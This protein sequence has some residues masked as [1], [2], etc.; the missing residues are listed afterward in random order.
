ELG[1]QE[2]V[3]GGKMSLSYVGDLMDRHFGSSWYTGSAL[4]IK[5]TNIVWPDDTIVAKAVVTDEAVEDG[6]KMANV[7]VWMEKQDGTVTVV[8]TAKTPV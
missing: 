4:D 5:F 7:A 8:G 6:R 1:F 2:V 3:V